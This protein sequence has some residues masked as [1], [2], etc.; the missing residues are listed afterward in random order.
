[1][2]F[3]AAL[4]QGAEEVRRSLRTGCPRPPEC[5]GAD[6]R[7]NLVPKRE[8]PAPAVQG[9]AVRLAIQF[10]EQLRH[11]HE[12]VPLLFEHGDGLVEGFDRR[13]V[14]FEVMQEIDGSA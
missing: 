13:L 11:G 3:I 10:V 8:F 9:V 14:A 4:V 12:D 5:C 2:D 6:L 1:M 7:Q